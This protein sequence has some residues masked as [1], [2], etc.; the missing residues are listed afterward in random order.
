M[1]I[2]QKLI[3]NFFLSPML[4]LVILIFLIIFLKKLTHGFIR[5]CLII[6]CV[7]TYFFSIEPVKDYFVQNLEK[8][9][10]P[11]SEVDLK[12]GD[13]YVLLGAG[14]YDK[15]PSSLGRVGIP[16]EIAMGRLVELVRLYRV[17]PKKIIVSGGIVISGKISESEIY[18]NYLIDLGVKPEDIIKEDKSKTTAENAKFTVELAKKLNY[19][20]VVVVT[21]A[22]HM[23]RAKK[24]FEKLGLM[25]IPAPG[26]Y[27]SDYEKYDIISRLPKTSNIEMTFRA[28]WEYIGA[29]YYKIKG[30]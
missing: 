18:K 28:F 23:E 5:T 13:F 4:M 26:A 10:T 21:S 19:K 24:S 12:K 17:C 27:I 7:I 30:V 11:V 8:K 9:Y 15:A 1:L 2:I 14:I 22:T 29:I 16:S 20:N 6:I 3:S 25:V